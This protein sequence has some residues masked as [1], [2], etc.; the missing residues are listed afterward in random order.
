LMGRH[1][2]G[3]FDDRKDC[4]QPKIEKTIKIDYLE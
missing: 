4:C 2:D 3:R 1:D